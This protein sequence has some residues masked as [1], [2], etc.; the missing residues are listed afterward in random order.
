MKNNSKNILITG[1][2]GGLGTATISELTKNQ[3]HVFASDVNPT[4]LEKY[5]DNKWVTP[6]LMDITDQS[7]IDKA[8]DVIAEQTS[9]LD[10]IINLTGILVVGSV[11]E[12]PIETIQKIIDINLLGAYRTNQKFLPLIINRKGRIINISSETGW[13]TAAPFNGAYALSKYALEAYSDALRRELAF[14][15]IKVIKIQ[16]GPFKTEM[17]KHIE[18]KFAKAENESKL[19]KKNLAKGQTYLPGVY[20]NAHEPVILAKTIVQVLNSKNPKTAYSLKSDKARSF[21]DKIPIRWA[22]KLIKRALS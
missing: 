6:V 17:T 9:G 12:L 5:K 7:D 3:W 16:P 8:F 4:I 2:F 22:D 14:L 1:A 20:K 13:Q 18:Q 19:F 15:D 10:A 21:L 11:V